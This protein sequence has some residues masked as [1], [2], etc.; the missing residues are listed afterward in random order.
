[1][2][3]NNTTLSNVVYPVANA[4]ASTNPFVDVFMDRAPTVNDVQYPTQK[5]WFNTANGDYYLLTNFTSL[6]GVVQA[7]WQIIGGTSNAQ[8]LTG[9]TGGAVFPFDNNINVVGDG[10][11]VNVVGNPATSTLTIEVASEVAITYTANSGTATASGGILNVL[12]GT[13]ATTVASGNTITINATA[14]AVAYTNVTHAMSPYTV[15][16]TDEYLSVDC[17]GGTVTLNFPNAPAA[18]KIWIVKDRTG[19]SAT[20]NITLTTP[21]GIV[22][23]DGGTSYALKINFEAVNILA[24]ST[25]TYEVF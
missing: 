15:L 8:S 13:G 9:N 3:I 24:N 2:T 18:N 17:S 11:T 21:G 19:N 16:T 22:T 12:G 6:G 10:V 4:A 14:V 5:K 20:N 7:V 25:P 1:M 23:F